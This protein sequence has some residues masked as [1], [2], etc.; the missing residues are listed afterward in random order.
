MRHN[1]ARRALLHYSRIDVQSGLESASPHRRVQMLMEG[2]LSRVAAAIGYMQHDRT[3]DKGASISGA[4]SIIAGLREGL[5][6][7]A[8]GEIASNLAKLYDYMVRRLLEANVNDD[9]TILDEIHHLMREIKHGWDAITGQAPERE[10]LAPSAAQAR[11]AA[12][13]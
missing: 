12:S 5:D 1:Q 11:R 9:A 6:L 4:I 2:A 13:A 8:G 10:P 7:E 3:A